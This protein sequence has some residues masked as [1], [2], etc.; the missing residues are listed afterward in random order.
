MPSRRR[1]KISRTTRTEKV[2]GFNQDM[3]I[4]SFRRFWELEGTDTTWNRYQI[5][6]VP[7]KPPRYIVYL[8]EPWRDEV[9]EI[10]RMEDKIQVRFVGDFTKDF[11]HREIRDRSLQGFGIGSLA[12]RNFFER[13]R[14]I[15]RKTNIQVSQKKSAVKLLLRHGYRLN[16][17]KTLVVSLLKK[18]GVSTTEELAKWVERQ[19]E[20]LPISIPLIK[21]F[22]RQNPKPT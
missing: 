9:F 15:P 6:K 7:T 13:E 4:K 2:L 17:A 16:P 8:K 20:E 18:R 19:E 12:I 5:W 21:R 22:R 1:P 10:V 11:V 14:V 3:V